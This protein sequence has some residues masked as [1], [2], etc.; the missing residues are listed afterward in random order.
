MVKP[1]TRFEMFKVEGR[2]RSPTKKFYL[3]WDVTFPNRFPNSVISHRRAVAGAHTIIDGHVMSQ[4]DD[5]G[6]LIIALPDQFIQWHSIAQG[7]TQNNSRK[8]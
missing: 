8:A 6:A 2:T 3:G 4:S 5:E 7:D 1:W